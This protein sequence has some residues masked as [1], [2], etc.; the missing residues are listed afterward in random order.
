M[1]ILSKV[2]FFLAQPSHAALAL[3]GLGLLLL[4]WQKSWRAGRAL[5]AVGFA[6]LLVIAFSPLGQAMLLPLEERFPHPST[7]P[8]NVAGII[9]LGGF[10][11]GN[12]SH[13]RG[14]LTLNES[15][16]RLTEAVILARKLPNTKVVFTGGSS[17]MF[18]EGQSGAGPIGAYL[19]AAGIEPERIIL[20]PDARN[21]HENAL[22]TRD[23]VQPKPGEVWLLVTSA[24][25]M[26][27]SI[28]VFRQAGFP[29][30]AYPVDYRT[31]GVQDLT[32]PF[33]AAAEGFRRLDIATREW[34]GLLAYWMVGRTTELWPGPEAP[35]SQ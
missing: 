31:R 14:M 18:R 30:T 20:E 29:V 16:E 9:I 21:T 22:L 23:L 11:D 27:R 28:A 7:P 1:V 25:H 24:A 2:I 6:L 35:S 15:A 26:P 3:T 33:G 8:D 10:E 19:A 5:V 32:Q 4:F 12:V 13:A 34:L 17:D